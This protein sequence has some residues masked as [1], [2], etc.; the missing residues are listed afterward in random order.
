MPSVL[1]NV[2]LMPKDDTSKLKDVFKG[3]ENLV[4]R[5]LF[6]IL[7]RGLKD[8]N[9]KNMPHVWS[10]THLIMLYLTLVSSCFMSGKDLS[11]RPSLLSKYLQHL[12][13][14]IPTNRGTHIREM[15]ISTME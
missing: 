2:E 15:K 5:G 14:E 9:A 12:L 11:L 4:L 3:F 13:N 6:E 7:E 8:T 1:C 10:E